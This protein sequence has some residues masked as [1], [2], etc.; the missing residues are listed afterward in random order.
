MRLKL[1]NE[2]K[3]SI[4]VKESMLGKYCTTRKM[5]R[6]NMSNSNPVKVPMILV[7]KLGKEEQ[8]EKVYGTNY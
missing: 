8:G 4:S 7:F 6:F 1:F 2:L 3:M 5:E